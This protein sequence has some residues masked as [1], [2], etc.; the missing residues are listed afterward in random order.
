MLQ[1][2]L[3][4]G[5]TTQFNV[6][7]LL[8][9]GP[10]DTGKTSTK[11]MLYNQPSPKERNSTDLIKQTYSREIMQDLVHTIESESA[12]DW[13]PVDSESDTNCRYEMLSNTIKSVEPKRIPVVASD[14]ADLP[15]LSNA[16]DQS[17]SAIE[18]HDQSLITKQ[19]VIRAKRML[20]EKLRKKPETTDKC[21]HNVRWILCRDSGGQSEFHDILPIFVHDTAVVIYVI[22]LS[23]TLAE[24]PLDDYYD[25]GRRLG[26]SRRSPYQVEQIL[27]SIF[28]SVC[29]NRC[30]DQ[31]VKVL[32]VGTHKDMESKDEPLSE[33]NRK[34]KCLLDPF[35]ELEEIEVLSQDYDGEDIIF[36]INARDQDDDSKMMVSYIRKGIMSHLESSKPVDVPI[37]WF[38]LEETL[39][40]LG[41][42][43]ESDNGII[44]RVKFEEVAKNINM[45]IEMAH[46]ALKYFHDLNIFLHFTQSEP[47][48]RFIFTKPQFVVT[49]VSAFVKEARQLRY[50]GIQDT[51]YRNLVKKGLFSS[52]IFSPKRSTLAACLVPSVGFNVDDVIELLKTMLIVAPA[53]VNEDKYFIPVVLQ[54]CPPD[55]QCVLKESESLP[56]CVV[57][58][59]IEPPGAR[60]CL[61]SGFFCAFICSLL[62]NQQWKLRRQL[63]VFKN[64]VRFDIK[65]MGCH[66]TVVD[67]FYFISVHV[68]GNCCNKDCR[69]ILQDINEAVERVIDLHHY[70]EIITSRD[71]EKVTQQS[72]QVPKE[73]GM[74]FL[75]LCGKTPEHKATLT[76]RGT[77][78]LKCNMNETLV[79]MDITDKHTVWFSESDGDQGMI[80]IV[81][82]YVLLALFQAPSAFQYYMQKTKEPG[83]K[84]VTYMT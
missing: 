44:D 5:V 41:C 54:H 3:E 10:A 4:E 35:V 12:Y 32:I 22:D 25:K 52:E 27:K 11:C 7:K 70:K 23:Q 57:P 16:E 17:Q 21:I 15:T 43:H 47:L 6:S 59:V 75:C 13:I 80:K 51:K 18:S 50:H 81:S 19:Y 29:Y 42:Q 14:A 82:V 40:T 65:D 71:I 61:P 46:K 45:S 1:E 26:D 73:Q 8:I 62:S 55:Y 66:V 77:Q 33:K 72:S 48:S 20:L 2:L 68:Y 84:F 36:P 31:K 69:I 83:K 79:I 30:H 9:T 34:I 49:T 39:R 28:Q 56:E 58:R 74:C 63:D 78:T 64:Y 37:S 38:L 24:Q 76:N 53:D 67:M 60:E